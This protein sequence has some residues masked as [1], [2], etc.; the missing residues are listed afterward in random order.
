[1]PILPI[2]SEQWVDTHA[3]MIDIP[4]EKI[5]LASKGTT[6]P[7]GLGGAISKTEPRYTFFKYAPPSS[8]STSSADDVILFIYTC[9]ATSKVKEKML[10]AASKR[11]L[12]STAEKE[13]KIAKTFEFSSPREEVTAGL[14]EAE[15]R[16][17]PTSKGPAAGGA[18]ARPKRPGR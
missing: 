11:A 14:L 8:P 3:K 18:F 1:M 2:A 13:L 6:T 9:P 17:A 10:Y 12:I 16:Q 15:F 4:T 5:N 7:E